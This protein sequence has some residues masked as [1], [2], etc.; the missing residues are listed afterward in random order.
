MLLVLLFLTTLFLAY[1]N[2]ANDNFK[3]VATLYGSYSA[4]YRTALALGTIATLLGG[5]SS[6]VLA[7]GLIKTFS[8]TGVV[9]ADVAS[10]HGFLLAVSAAA[11]LTVIM[12]TILGLPISTTHALTG[13]IVGAGFVAVGPHLNLAVLGR[14]L[15]LP[16]LVSPALAIALTLPIYH[17]LHTLS[18]R[19]GLTR[20]TCVCLDGASRTPIRSLQL[21]PQ[22]DG[23]WAVAYAGQTGTS[24]TIASAE[25]CVQKYGGRMLGVKIQALTD[26]AHYLSAAA[27]SFAR[28]LNDTPKILALLLA[29]R[30]FDIRLG[31]P[32][33]AAAMAIGGALN[34]RQVAQA[35]GRKIARMNDGQALT[36]NLVSAFLVIVASRFGLP[37]STTHVT[38]GAITGVG[39][40]NG[41]V[42]KTMIS[43]ILAS[44]LVTLP[45]AALLSAGVALAIQH[46]V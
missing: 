25:Q 19:T 5:L 43:G 28:G 12:A 17:L 35:I 10:S 4:S 45:T 23:A 21:K 22:T 1:A 42:N 33:I 30:A 6:L 15:V 36:A 2:G 24:I 46:H 9:P 29:A 18:R 32:A 3:G 31:V 13:A 14:A 44:W 37:V 11:A 39:L 16:L 7:T 38:I 40:I 34:A 26:T 8:G 41:S 27:L 20:E